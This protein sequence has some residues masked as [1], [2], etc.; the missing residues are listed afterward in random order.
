MTRAYIRKTGIREAAEVPKPA[1]GK[2][3]LRKNAAARSLLDMPPEIIATVRE[4][5]GQD[6]Q[7]VTDTVHGKVEAAMRQDFAIN[8][9]EPVTPDMFGGIFDGMYTRKGHKGEIEYGGL[10]LMYRPLELTQEAIEED[11]KARDSAMQAQRT[12]IKDGVLPGMNG[13][14]SVN[15]G[16]QKAQAGSYLVRKVTPPMEIPSD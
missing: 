1:H 3:R 4:E 10:I 16:N 5:Y 6:L 14:S 7:W 11:Q 2:T 12:M 13:A 9:W 8:A 15:A